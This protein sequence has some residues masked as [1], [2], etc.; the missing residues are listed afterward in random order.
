MGLMLILISDADGHG[1]CSVVL[2]LIKYKNKGAQR[3]QK[4]AH[5]R[6]S[7]VSNCQTVGSNLVLFDSVLEVQATPVTE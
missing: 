2:R 4:K 7:G 1:C 6:S 3:E 5:G